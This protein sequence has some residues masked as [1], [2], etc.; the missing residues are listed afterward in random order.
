MSGPLEVGIVPE[1]E[2][3]ALVPGGGDEEV[4]RGVGARAVE[5]GGDPAL[6]AGGSLEVGLA[7][8]RSTGLEVG[9]A[10][11]RIVGMELAVVG[12]GD[13]VR[14]MLATWPALI[15]SCDATASTALHLAAARP[16]NADVVR[17][18]LEA[19]AAKWDF[20]ASGGT[21]PAAPL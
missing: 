11:K 7:V 18:L 12:L 14:A 16:G 19:G 4:L 5:L 21:P 15:F 13:V 17:A 6:V 2:G 3:E 10:V 9:L 1:V 8:G 20:N